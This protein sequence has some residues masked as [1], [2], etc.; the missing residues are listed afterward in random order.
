MRVWILA[1]HPAWTGEEPETQPGFAACS[2]SRGTGC[3]EKACLPSPSPGSFHSKVALGTS[4]K[5]NYQNLCLK[6]GVTLCPWQPLCYVI[7]ECVCWGCL[8][9]IPFCG[10]CTANFLWVNTP[11]NHMVWVGQ[12]LTTVP[13]GVLVTSQAWQSDSWPQCLD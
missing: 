1:Q 12:P 5:V 2:R 10:N 4:V 9:F 3:K 6:R 11:N 13:R 8:S 7:D